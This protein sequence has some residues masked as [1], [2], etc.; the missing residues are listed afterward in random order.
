MVGEAPGIKGWFVSINA[1]LSEVRPGFSPFPQE[2]GQ[3]PENSPVHLYKIRR[4]F[5]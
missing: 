5:D 4:N 2:I 1:R 3:L